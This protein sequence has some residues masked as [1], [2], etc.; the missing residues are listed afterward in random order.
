[1]AENLGFTQGTWAL[2][3]LLLQ[4][5]FLSLENVKVGDKQITDYILQKVIDETVYYALNNYA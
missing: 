2:G 4:R 3:V 5:R 1:M